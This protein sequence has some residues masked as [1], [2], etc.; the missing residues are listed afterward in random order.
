FKSIISK[1]A[2]IFL[3]LFISI[4]TLTVT[5]DA[6]RVKLFNTIIKNT[7]K[8]LDIEVNEE[9]KSE[10]NKIEQNIDEFYELEYIPGGFE[11]DYVEDL[12][13]TKIVN[14][15]NNK[16]EEILFNQSP[17]GTN[18]QLDSED[19]AI[20]EIDIIGNEGI[21]LKKEDRTTLFWNNEE[22]SFYLLSTINEK[23]L[24]SMAKSLIK[25]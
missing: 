13:D 3:I 4:A 24:I 10:I 6:F 5:V 1:V 15:I 19:A 16:N 9:P 14:Y 23:E 11:L 7:E 25:K 2:I 22:Y 12:G 21:I 20:R 17:N 18:F 8:Y